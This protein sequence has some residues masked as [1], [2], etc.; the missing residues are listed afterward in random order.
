MPRANRAWRGFFRVLNRIVWLSV[1]M[2][3]AALAGN[4]VAYRKT[5]F[6]KL[7][8]FDESMAASEDQELSMRASKLGKVVYLRKIIAKTSA[9]RLEKLGFFG[10]LLNWGETT[11]NLIRGK[12]QKNYLITR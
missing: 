11:W 4:V 2:R 7:K 5:T 9:R 8:G 1:K 10:L 3:N 6:E 12:K